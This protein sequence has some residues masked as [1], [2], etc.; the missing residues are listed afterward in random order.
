[1]PEI[2]EVGTKVESRVQPLEGTG[3]LILEKPEVV[4]EEESVAFDRQERPSSDLLLGERRLVQEGQAGQVRRF[5]EVDGKGNR[6]P[7][8]T[9]V[10][11]ESVTEIVEVGTKVESRVEPL[12]G[13]KV[14]EVKE[15]SLIIEEETIA[16]GREER[17]NPD[18]LAGERHLVQEGVAGLRRNLV[19]VDSEGK[20]SLKGTEVL[21]EAVTEIVEVGTKVV[22]VAPEKPELPNK[23]VPVTPEKPELPNKVAPVAP[24]KPD[25]SNKVVPVETEKP[26]VSYQVVQPNKQGQAKAEP[27]LEQASKQELPN[28]GTVVDANLVALGLAG[29]LSGFGLLV[30]K[31]KED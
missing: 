30:Q 23:V 14:L 2:V 5:F 25:L 7:L 17:K 31:R 16:F 3:Y 24:D 22:P 4:T 10:V 12:E 6:T 26:E 15:P 8:Q 19:E 20:R 21:K 27:K 1:M 29:V 28:T 13:P 11:K 9:E 18:L